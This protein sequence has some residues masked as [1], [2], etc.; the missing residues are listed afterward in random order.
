METARSF[1]K[2]STV[3]TILSIVTLGFYNYYINYLTTDKFIGN[4][5]IKAKTKA[6]ETVSAL[7]FAIVAATLVHTYVM[8]P[9]TI[10]TSSLEKS[11]LVGD[12]LFVSKFHYGARVPQT[13]IALPMV[14]DSIPGTGVKS[15]W[16][17]LQ[18]PGNENARFSRY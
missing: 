3:D 2:N 11:L 18:L 7:L 4:R 13:P 14:H 9:F 10:P 1:G 8:Q 5:S 16:S 12:F 17:D 15:Y 6:G